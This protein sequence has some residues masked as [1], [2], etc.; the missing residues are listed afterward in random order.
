MWVMIYLTGL[1][2]WLAVA[3]LFG[4]VLGKVIRRTAD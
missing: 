3:T 4:I 2:I 1:G